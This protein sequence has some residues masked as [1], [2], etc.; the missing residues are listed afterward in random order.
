M[1][2]E[3]SILKKK[4]IILTLCT[5]LES[6]YR[7]YEARL[8]RNLTI[9]KVKYMH[10]QGKIG[11]FDKSVVQI[12]KKFLNQTKANKKE[13]YFFLYFAQDII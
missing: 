12:I 10:V 7:D 8:L 5:N 4:L 1:K 3:I 6:E 11:L 13:L 9:I 2:I